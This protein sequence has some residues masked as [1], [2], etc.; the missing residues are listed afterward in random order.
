MALRPG[1]RSEQIP[2]PDPRHLTE[3]STDENIPM[4]PPR[5]SLQMWSL[6]QAQAGDFAAT[7]QRV[8]EMGYTA[9]ELAGFGNLGTMA[10]V[11]AIESAGLR[12]SGMHVPWHR[13]RG[14]W[15]AVVSEARALATTE[16]ICPW[17]DPAQ[18]RS[19]AACQR[20]GREL[21]EAGARLRELGFSLSFHNHGVELSRLEGRAVLDWILSA[22]S[23]RDLSLE[24]D[25]YWA[26]SAGAD[27]VAILRA[28]AGQCRQIHVKNRVGLASGP[29]DYGRLVTEA[30]ETGGVEWWI[31]EQEVFIG[32]PFAALAENL[33][34]WREGCATTAAG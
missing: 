4:Y 3:E 6:R 23:A 12:V 8:A 25:A 7:V 10:A 26:A 31:I 29:V 2:E 14:D 18:Y 17:W 11:K 21:G 13:I 1:R 30:G 28:Y 20:I 24:L 15:L 22:A 19:P 34:I 27:P 33:R 9:I 5:L 16:I 32:D